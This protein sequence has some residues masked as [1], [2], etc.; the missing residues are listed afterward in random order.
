MRHRGIPRGR[1]CTTIFNLDNWSSQ[2]TAA[3]SQQR[4]LATCP[5]SLWRLFFNVLPLIVFLM[6]LRW[7]LNDIW[8]I[9]IIW[10]MCIYIISMPF[11][12]AFGHFL[13]A[14]RCP[15]C[16]KIRCIWSRATRS[17][18]VSACKASHRRSKSSAWHWM[19]LPMRHQKL[20]HHNQR[21]NINWFFSDT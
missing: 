7:N 17:H 21:S 11:L 3:N 6:F 15:I 5:A 18:S 9:N 16:G 19:R 1:F 10:C 2:A 4:T 12:D 14:L 8:I 20:R 13:K